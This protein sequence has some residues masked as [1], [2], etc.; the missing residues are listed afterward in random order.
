MFYKVTLTARGGLSQKNIEHLVSYFKI[1][2]H[3]YLVNEHGEAGGNSHL[4]GIVE[5][6]TKNTS[7]VTV[8]IQKQYEK[9]EVEVVKGVTICVK[10][11]TH[12][13][14]AIIYASDELQRIEDSKLVLLRG[15]K[16]S[17]ISEQIKDNVKNIPHKLLRK[18]GTR[19]T[20]G[21][22]AALIREWCLANN[23]Q[24]KYKEDYLEVIDRMGD[25]AYMFGKGLHIGL[26]ADVCALFLDGSGG[27]KVA[28]SELRFID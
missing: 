16:E 7:N 19:V 9:M 1:C 12:L 27:R 25:E 8:R 21:T 10:V 11:V 17:W 28:E 5:F 20:A 15:W 22:G 13:V 6:D 4:E 24:I 23:M 14:G 26:F 3:A 2:K 18:Q